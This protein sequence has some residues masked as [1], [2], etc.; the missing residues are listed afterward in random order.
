MWCEKVRRY[1]LDIQLWYYSR[2][3]LRKC[4]QDK[5]AI[6]RAFELPDLKIFVNFFKILIL[7]RY[8]KKI[9]FIRNWKLCLKYRCCFSLC[10]SD[11]NVDFQWKISK[12]QVPRRNKQSYATEILD[13]LGIPR[14][15]FVDEHW[16]CSYM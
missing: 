14:K 6:I 8:E 7:C 10:A 4:I 16:R 5:L 15:L 3:Q 2:T 1:R 9:K 11:F 12:V 13:Q